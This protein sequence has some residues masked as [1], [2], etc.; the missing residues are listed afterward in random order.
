[1]SINPLSIELEPSL[2]DISM[3]EVLADCG[4][5]KFTKSTRTEKLRKRIILR[6]KEPVIITRFFFADTA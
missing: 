1:M 3:S 5:R 2:L 4:I 6:A